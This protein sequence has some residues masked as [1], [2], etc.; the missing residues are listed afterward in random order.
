MT[1][2][3]NSRYDPH[4]PGASDGP[5]PV[6]NPTEARQG[7]TPGRVRYVLVIGVV[8]VIVAFFFSYLGTRP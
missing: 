8:L 5:T 1:D 2:D 6:R 3:P 7:A 4:T